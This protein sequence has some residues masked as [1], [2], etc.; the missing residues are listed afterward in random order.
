M[1]KNEAGKAAFLKAIN[2]EWW[3]IPQDVIDRL[4]TSMPARME[5][6]VANE[7]WYTKY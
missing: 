2:K 3:A 1:G 5:A 6:V 4:I 7:G